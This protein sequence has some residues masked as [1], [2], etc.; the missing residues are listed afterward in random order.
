MRIVLSLAFIVATFGAS[1]PIRAA[2]VT[3]LVEFGTCGFAACYGGSGEESFSAS[4]SDD[5]GEPLQGTFW[6]GSGS[7]SVNRETGKIKGKQNINSG[8]NIAG[9]PTVRVTGTL[10]LVLQIVAPSGYVPN[11]PVPLDFEVGLDGA[12]QANNVNNDIDNVLNKF[13]ASLEVVRQFSF[14]TLTSTGYDYQWGAT[15]SGDAFFHNHTNFVNPICDGCTS[16]ILV[17][18]PVDE[19]RNGFDNITLVQHLD[20]ELI[21]GEFF[22]VTLDIH[23]F[24]S[25]KGGG[26]AGNWD[27]T[28]SLGFRLPEGFN[29]ADVQGNVVT[30]WDLRVVPLAPA[31]PL[32]ASAVGA[33]VAWQR[34]SVRRA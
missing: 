7:V 19:F 29:L 34:R 30:G 4:G 31:W 2:S 11:T 17:P 3:A 18:E 23:S 15:T 1:A 5:G 6:S 32:F 12:F 9:M 28:A 13:T 16:N 8:P 10:Q 33:L 25:A 14:A 20:N 26:G 27:N 21:A 22:V 24:S